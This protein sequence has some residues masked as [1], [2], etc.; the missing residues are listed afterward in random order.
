MRT[1]MP[2]F[3]N[4]PTTAFVEERYI[5]HLPEA[6]THDGLY[7]RILCHEATDNEVDLAYLVSTYVDENFV[8]GIFVET[9]PDDSV[10]VSYDE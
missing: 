1:I 2:Y 3:T 10:A 6:I 8:I 4:S 7:A 9:I 5:G